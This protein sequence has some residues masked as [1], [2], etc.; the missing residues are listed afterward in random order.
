[1]EVSEDLATKITGDAMVEIDKLR[2]SDA[3]KDQLIEIV[4]EAMTEVLRAYLKRCAPVSC[5]QFCAVRR[6]WA[7]LT[8]AQSI[9]HPGRAPSHPSTA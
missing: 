2:K 6:A 3:D 8:S 9:C 1:M 4:H 7:I 5:T